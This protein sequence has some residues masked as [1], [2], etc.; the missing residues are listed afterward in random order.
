MLFKSVRNKDAKDFQTLTANH[1]CLFVA[2]EC[3]EVGRQAYHARDYY[4]TVKWMQEAFDRSTVERNQTVSPSTVLDFLTF[5]LYKVRCNPL[6]CKCDG[7]HF[8]T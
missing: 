1:G 7:K 8:I 3:F 2:G 4:H 6:Q 5:A